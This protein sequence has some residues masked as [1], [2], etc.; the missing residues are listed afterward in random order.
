MRKLLLLAIVCLMGISLLPGQMIDNEGFESGVFPPAGWVNDGGVTL[1]TPPVGNPAPNPPN[2]YGSFAAYFVNPTQGLIAPKMANPYTLTIS[3]YQTGSGNCAPKYWYSSSLAGPWTIVESFN[4]LTNGRWNL[5]TVTV[6]L[7]NVYLKIGFKQGGNTQAY[8]DNITITPQD[9]VFTYRTVASGNWSNPNIWEYS[10]DG[11]TWY[12]ANIPPSASGAVSITIRNGHSVTA[13]ANVTADELTVENSATL[14]INSG[15]VFTL[16]NG[17]GTDMVMNGNLVN[18]GT[19]AFASGATMTAGT[20]SN[21]TYNGVAAQTLGAGF[22]TIV[23]N[24]T[25]NNSN[26]VNMSS[27]LTVNGSLQ[28]IAGALATGSNTVTVNSSVSFSSTSIISGAGSFVLASGTTLSTA[29]PFGIMSSGAQGSVQT[30]SRTFNS[31]ANYSYNGSASQVTGSG[32]PANVNNLSI[33][34]S[35]GVALSGSVQVN[36]NLA[37]TTGLAIGSG[38]ILGING[39][40]TG[41]GGL[42]GG[43]S[44]S[45]NISGSGNINI[46][47]VSSLGQLSI[48]RTGTA[49]LGSNLVVHSSLNLNTN[50]A[51]N[52]YTLTLMGTVPTATGTL[53]GGG[54]SSIV[55]NSNSHVTLP[56]VSSTLRDLVIGNNSSVTTQSAISVTNS[57]QN[58]GT[59]DVLG[60]GISG[61]GSGTN[62]GTI[63]STIPNPIATA[64]YTQAQGSVM[65]FDADT[66]LPSGFTYQNL[67][68][69]SPSTLFSLSGDVFVNETFR[70]TNNASLD[71][72]GFVMHF[73][74]KYVSVTGDVTI[75]AFDPETY[76][77][78]AGTGGVTRKWT[79]TGSASASPIVYLHWDNEQGEAVDFSNG[80]VI[81]KF[82]GTEWQKLGR[83]G[84]PVADGPTRMKVGFLATL[85]SKDDSEGQYSVTGYDEVLPIALS[86][87]N[88][89]LNASNKVSLMWVTQTETNVSGFRIYR[90]NEQ[91]IDT[92]TQ[93]SV[94]IPATNTSQAQSYVFVDNE[95]LEQGMYY[96]WLENLDMDGSS[97]M[98]GPVSVYLSIT[99]V[100]TPD[101]PVKNGLNSAYPNPFNP[102]VTLRIGVEKQDKV[103]VSIYNSRGQL[104]KNLMQSDLAKGIWSLRWD[105]RDTYGKPCAS[106]VYYAR[107][108]TGS[109]DVSQIK[110][111]LMK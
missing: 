21:I 111:M 30:S 29:N 33:N 81:W 78:L 99:Q 8:F 86:S 93:L 31:N 6:N 53:V 43:A 24:L 14:S 66:T 4:N 82:N 100:V 64:T 62:S 7:T 65:Q 77:G 79:F 41:S 67:V 45:L 23:N 13:T 16:A 109:G 97:S 88:A 50:L 27:A 57:F 107:M 37:L 94:F 26:G 19:L 38:N 17:T 18:S 25:I 96:Y 47:S 74:F 3:A 32:L 61:S 60:F 55:V 71:L 36:A 51:L 59:I 105:G 52:G 11:I 54:N 73:P 48:N 42:T 28:M 1:G 10:R 89:A 98:F 70:T 85:G 90:S 20:S 84:A 15:V 108:N 80:S 22:P 72:S 63:I 83:V 87:F 68:L 104:V 9:F 103:S 58:S 5:Q 102:N 76:P 44:S 46:P 34:N 75:S 91:I 69:N 92:A 110:L 39:T 35:A 101:I 12:A 2:L 56:P 106:G 95:A 40:V 49:Y